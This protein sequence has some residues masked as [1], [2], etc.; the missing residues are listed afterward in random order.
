MDGWMDWWVEGWKNEW[1]DGW[2]TWSGVSC[3]RRK[4]LKAPQVIPVSDQGCP[5]YKGVQTKV[6]RRLNAPHG[7]AVCPIGVRTLGGVS[8]WLILTRCSKA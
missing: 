8:L 5:L 7:Q 1:V 2:M 4:V 6:D 3:V